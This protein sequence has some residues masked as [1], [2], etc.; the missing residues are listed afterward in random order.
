MRAL[1]I[2][3]LLLA[4]GSAQAQFALHTWEIGVETD[5]PVYFSI[6]DAFGRTV[7]E[8]TIVSPGSDF[9]DY[10]VDLNSQGSVE[11]C[12]FVWQTDSEHLQ[13]TVGSTRYIYVP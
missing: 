4:C 3:S 8:P 11:D 10:T 1:F 5:S 13:I 2:L 12:D 6:Y 7:C 9:P